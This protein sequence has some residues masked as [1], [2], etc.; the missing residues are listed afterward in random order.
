VVLQMRE[1]LCGPLLE[2]F[3]IANLRIFAKQIHRLLVSLKLCLV[4]GL[5]ELLAIEATKLVQLFLVIRVEGGRHV[6]AFGGL[7]ASSA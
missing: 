6:S 7:R 5:I 2:I 4:V 1:R 3:V